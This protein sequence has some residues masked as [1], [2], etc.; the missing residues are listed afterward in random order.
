MKILITDYTF[1]ASAQ[2]IDLSAEDNFDIKRLLAII[3]LTDQEIIFATSKTGKGY[4]TEVAGLV[5]LEFDTTAMDDA[6]VLQVFYEREP[7]ALEGNIALEAGGNLAAILAKLSADPA[8]QTTLAAILAK[9][10]ADPATQTTLAA[11]LAKI[12]AA[13][14]TEGKQ[15][16]IITALT[17]IAGYTDGVEPLLTAIG[18][19]LAGTLSVGLPGNA[20]QEAGGNLATIAAKDFA[21]QTTLAAILAKI[22]AAPATEA[23]QDTGNTSLATIAAKD[24]ATQ[25]TLAAILAKIIAAPATEA[26]QDTGNTSLATIAAKDFATQTTLA[27][28]LAK[29]IAAPA[30]EAK[31]DTMITA[32]QTIDNFISGARGLVTEDNSN[33]IKTAVEIIDNMISGNY[34][35]VKQFAE[36]SGGWTNYTLVA[37]AT[38]NA[39]SLKAAAGQVGFITAY[40]LNAAARYLKF[41]NKASAPSPGSDTP[42]HVVMIPGNT[43]GA[44]AVVPVPIGMEFTTGIAFAVVA[45]IS[46]TDN[47]SVAASEIIINIGYK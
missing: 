40:N 1:D 18:N 31:Q 36:T 6:D 43:G 25:T 33:A 34:G 46:A 32:L 9:L 8:T 37:A 38:N 39:T 7:S 22:I 35:Q 27:A 30:T 2:T 10:T 29:I 42:V 11:I 28:V 14:A 47:T 15:D 16:T 21:T 12:I 13:P 23:K 24:F 41:Y 20:A 19:L 44:G 5:T 3:N 4:T 17:A 26:K 45:G